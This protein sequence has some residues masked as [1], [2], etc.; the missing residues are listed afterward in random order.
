[1]HTPLRPCLALLRGSMVCMSAL[2]RSALIATDASVPQGRPLFTFGIIADVQWADHEDGYNFAQTTVRRYRG[3]FRTLQ[4]AVNWWLSLPHPPLF[5]ANLGDIIDGINAK[6][7]HSSLALD[8]ALGELARLPCPAVNII[9]N[10]ELYNFNRTELS[11]APWLKH[12]DREF[13]SFSPADGWRVVVLDPYQIAMIGHAAYDPRHLT[14]VD[15]IGQ[16]NPGV[17]AGEWF[18]RV[19]GNDK[20]FVPY[21]GGL[22]WEQLQWLRRQLADAAAAGERVIILCH[23][24]LH[25][26]ACG[27]GTMLWDFPEA[28]EAIRSEEA[29]GCVA[30]VFCGHDHFGR[31]FCDE[32]GVHHCTFCSPLNKGDEGNAFGLVRVWNERIEIR[33]LHMNDLLPE[34]RRGEP[35]GRPA[36]TFCE[37]DAFSGPCETI[38]LPV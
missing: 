31:Y 35:T 32:Y 15:L 30:A 25:P 33:G 34:V 13:H 24:I 6:L 2:P 37:G 8:A 21:N 9:G 38:T 29:G 17:A 18:A 20:R 7:G 19:E 16:R 5:I 26:R 12:G 27:G 10:H 28:L 36:S 4:R 1:M 14:A 23:V 3:A 22:G 11:R